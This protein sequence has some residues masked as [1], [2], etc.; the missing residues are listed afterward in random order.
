MHYVYVLKNEKEEIHVGQTKDIK[1]RVRQHKAGANKS[2]KNQQW[3]L[4]Y[5]EASKS[6][7]DALIREKRL[8][9]HGQAK[10]QLKERI[11][12]SLSPSEQ[13]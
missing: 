3:T 13:N 10:R 1:E 6:R 8:K 9:Q 4:V 5:Y 11:K 7:D 2:T 12:R